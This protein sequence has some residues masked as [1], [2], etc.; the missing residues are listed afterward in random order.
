M[1]VAELSNPVESDWFMDQGLRLDASPYVAGSMK[2]KKMLEQLPR[3]ESLASL[4][5][6]RN[7]G[8]FNG[9]MF[10]RVYLTDPEH[11]VPFL[12]TK[13]MMAADLTG[14]PRLRKSDAE[15][16]TLSYL[17]LKPG[18]TLIS[19]SGFNA[20][21]RAYVR[22]DMSD[23]WSSQDTLKVEPNP[24]KIKSGY[25]YAFLLSKFGES[26]VRGSVYGSAV[27]HIEPHHIAG[28][29]VPRLEAELEGRIHDLVEEC[30]Q[31]RAEFQSSSVSATK[32]LFTSVG[33]PELID[34]RWHQQ[35]RDLGFEVPSVGATS[36]RALN[37]APRARQLAEK[38]G[39]VSS[40][41]LGDICSGGQLS[42]G[43]RFSR[44][45]SDP[46]NGVQL[47]GQRQA[48]WL[49]PEGRWIGK[50]GTPTQVFAQDETILIAAQGTLGENEVYCRPILTTGSWLKYAYSEH[51]LRVVSGDPEISGAY[52]FAFFRS[53][54]AFR[55]LR[56]LSAGGKQQDIHEHLR[57]AIPVPLAPL[58]DRKRIAATV[59]H[60][61]K[62]RD[63]ADAL[64]DQAL[65]L[66]TT[67]IE[68]AVG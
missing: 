54:A 45:D 27:K 44:V 25:L 64:E 1:K 34:V 14:L 11:S 53:E 22:P 35:E 55:L 52:L 24:E 43:A 19:C 40:S 26:L 16:S 3:T 46:D 10:R 59:R 56:S 8:I 7:G 38:L 28:L 62:C 2:T 58:A 21:R 39:S 12:G 60:A 51:F 23:C 48:F 17:Q 61:Y 65:A 41:K 9:P 67:A 4:T 57:A 20:G 33:L 66:L 42:R 63:E 31:L 36:L 47:V 15:S 13:D 29:P 6:G 68:E 30:A 32:D 18:M 50:S 49:R 37:F 5:A